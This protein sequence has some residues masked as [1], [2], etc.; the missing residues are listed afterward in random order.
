MTARFNWFTGVAEVAA[1]CPSALQ[2]HSGLQAFFEGPNHPDWGAV[3]PR[4]LYHESLHFWQLASSRHLQLLVAAEWERLLAFEREGTVPPRSGTREGFGRVGGDEPFSV[5]DLIECL[6]RYW[7]VHTRGPT[8]I[9][10]EE[11]NDLGGML[12]AI[13]AIRPAGA[14]SSLEFDTVMRTGPDC[15]VYA[16]PYHWMME[17]AHAATAVHSLPGNV[18]ESASWSV[19]LLLPLAGFL[20]LNTDAPVAAFL[21]AFQRGLSEDV[22]CE[23]AARRHPLKAINLDWLDFWDVL[24]K[25]LSRTLKRVGL[26]TW[27]AP[28]VGFGVLESEAFLDHPVYRHLRA[29]MTALDEELA[30]RRESLRMHYLFNPP[31][32]P[33][34]DIDQAMD[35]RATMVTQSDRWP[36]FSLPGQPTFRSLLGTVFA[37]PVVR[38]DDHDLLAT[39]SASSDWPWPIDADALAAAVDEAETRFAALEA[40]DTAIRLGLPPDTFVRAVAHPH[41]AGR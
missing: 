9:L 38:F 4:Q 30:H 1:P 15:E 33:A 41:A 18:Q 36:V 19:N 26:P 27:L 25:G 6:A 5:R 21:A 7:D 24:A 12:D 8:R 28:W 2:G 23:A 11:G 17:R 32:D 16:R 22:L 37:P 10:R 20:A 3:L 14:Y 40:A 34:E 39:A 35:L 31:P 13:D 29:R